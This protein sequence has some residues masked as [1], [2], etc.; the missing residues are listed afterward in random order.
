MNKQGTHL[1]EHPLC[2]I[3]RTLSG[4][5]DIESIFS[6]FFGDQLE[7]I[8]VLQVVLIADRFA[9]EI[10]GL[11]EDGDQGFRPEHFSTSSLQ[12]KPSD[13]VGYHLACIEFVAYRA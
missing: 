4:Q 3:A 12:K 13:N 10:M 1:T 6:T 2:D 8:Q 5:T 11:I 7:G 9:Q